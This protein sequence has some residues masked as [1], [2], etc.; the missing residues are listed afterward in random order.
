[1]I[2]PLRPPQPPKAVR[3]VFSLVG[4]IFA[5]I[6]VTVLVFLWIQPFGGFGSPPLF[7]RI[8]GSFIAL[9]FVVMGGASALGILTGRGLGGSSVE[10]M[11]QSLQEAMDEDDDALGSGAGYTCTQCGA[12]LSEQADVS[13]H[14]DTKCKYCNCWFN[15]H[16]K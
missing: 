14:G 10:S 2:R 4:L 7:F 16:G 15:V 5:G 6:G 1:M 11:A 8:F 3:V 12:P 13:P 9:A